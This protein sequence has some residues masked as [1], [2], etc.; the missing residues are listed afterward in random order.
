MDRFLRG[1]AAALHL[2]RKINHHDGVLLHDTNEQDDA[3]QGD[4]IELHVEEQ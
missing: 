2:Q 1:L 4:H 3:N